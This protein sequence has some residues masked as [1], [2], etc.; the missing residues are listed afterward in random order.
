[1]VHT[2]PTER[3]VR[4]PCPCRVRTWP[5]LVCC[6][7]WTDSSACGCSPGSNQSFSS[8]SSSSRMPYRAA[9]RERQGYGRGPQG[10]AALVAPR[11]INQP[12]SQPSW[13]APK[14]LGKVVFWQGR[15][16]PAKG[17]QE[18]RGRRHLPRGGEVRE[19]QG[20]GA[21]GNSVRLRPSPPPDLARRRGPD[22]VRP[23]PAPPLTSPHPTHIH[24]NVHIIISVNPLVGISVMVWATASVK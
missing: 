15:G 7:R 23:D 10:A 11:Q 8:S 9:S 3:K 22:P 1:M 16:N 5:P 4:R 17:G 21:R 2:H 18:A 6:R 19:P 20:S 13:R 14:S 24:A 12:T